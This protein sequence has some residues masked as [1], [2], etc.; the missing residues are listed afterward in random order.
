MRTWNLRVEEQMLT[1]YQ[2]PERCPWVQ[3]SNDH[4]DEQ[5]EKCRKAEWK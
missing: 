4:D 5:T 3:P 1:D 2:K